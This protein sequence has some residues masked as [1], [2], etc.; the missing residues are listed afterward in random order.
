M[1]H[2]IRG[3]S[4]KLVALAAHS[5]QLRSELHEPRLMHGVV[6]EQLHM[7]Q[8]IMLPGE[9]DAP[10]PFVRR[11]GKVQPVLLLEPVHHERIRLPAIGDEEL[12]WLLPFHCGKQLLQI[13]L[14]TVRLQSL[15]WILDHRRAATRTR[16]IPGHRVEEN[17]VPS[18][19]LRWRVMFGDEALIA[20]E[21]DIHDKI[22]RRRP[23]VVDWHTGL[24]ALSRSGLG[25]GAR[26]KLCIAHASIVVRIVPRVPAWNDSRLPWAR[27]ILG[28]DMQRDL[29]ILREMDEA[30]LI[31]EA[32]LLA[33]SPQGIRLFRGLDHR[34]NQRVADGQHPAPALLRLKAEGEI[35]LV[36][37]PLRITA[38][39]HERA[40]G[41]QHMR[42]VRS[43]W[44]F[45]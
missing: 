26:G 7:P 27:R 30:V 12:S 8:A 32:L 14:P 17:A 38:E 39:V 4:E 23:P 15:A 2:E 33:Q 45:G 29:R 6:L 10:P 35:D 18:R 5:R 31:V 25:V 16:D 42:A 36:P 21:A 19:R 24:A 9:V 43:G 22:I 1:R 37:H 44:Q 20:L 34:A 41:G 13:A 28:A 3:E 11:G 40:H